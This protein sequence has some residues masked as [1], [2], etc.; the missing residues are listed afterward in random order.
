MAQGSTPSGSQADLALLHDVRAIHD[1]AILRILDFTPAKGGFVVARISPQPGS[2][3]SEIPG[4]YIK[5]DT[6][7]FVTPRGGQILIKK[8]GT[9]RT[10]AAS[11]PQP[12]EGAYSWTEPAV[13]EKR[14]PD[15]EDL[16]SPFVSGGTIVHRPS[17][18]PGTESYFRN[19]RLLFEDWAQ[20]FPP[21]V[22]FAEQH[23]ASFTA[24]PQPVNDAELIAYIKGS[25]RFLTIEAFRILLEHGRMTALNAQPYASATLD[26]HVSGVMTYLLVAS[27][28]EIGPAHDFQRNKIM[29]V[30]A[31][32]A[33]YFE[34]RAQVVKAANA[35]LS[36]L[37]REFMRLGTPLT[38]PS[39]QSV[40]Q[41][42]Q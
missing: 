9:W 16:Y 17:G 4:A 22:S 5:A 23:P 38:D 1:T 8:T 25:N 18:E 41:G 10:L 2:G 24:S 42:V 19:A 40:F 39:L 3:G 34:P 27:G 11:P 7:E 36:A 28:Q 21:A 31:Y 6:G 32:S 14:A 13:R 30:A 35:S 20:E 15:P 37:R 33:R 29:A 12:P 26:A